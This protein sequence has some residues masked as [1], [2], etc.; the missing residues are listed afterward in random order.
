MTALCVALFNGVLTFIGCGPSDSQLSEPKECAEAAERLGYQVCVHTVTEEEIWQSVTAQTNQVTQPRTTKY[1]VPARK[2]ARLP[3]LF[4]DVGAFEMHLI[5]MV[6]AFPDIFP[7]LTA[8]EYERLILDPGERE[9][10]AGTIY[11]YNVDNNERIFGFVVWDE[12]KSVETTIECAEFKSV[13]AELSRV[14][15][16]GQLAV[17]PATGFQRDVLKDCDVPQYDPF[18]EIEYE[19]Y[20]VAMG[21]G[22]VRRYTLPE[23]SAATDAAEFGWQDI[24]ILDEAP[25]DIETVVSGAVTGTRQGALS[26]LNVRSA[27][28]NTPNCYLKNAYELFEEWEGELVRLQCGEKVLTVE[29]ATSEEA[30]EWW[31][32]LRPEPVAVLQPDLAARDF[33]GLLELPT[34]TAN[35]RATG[36]IRYGS[37]GLNLAALYQRIDPELQLVGFLIPF[38]YYDQFT[39]ANS[40]SVDMGSG[41]EQ[42]TF[43]ET[44]AKWLDNTSFY[45]DGALR[46][47]RLDA[48]RAA[49]RAAPCDEDLVAALESE[50][51]DRYGSNEV[52]VRF[53]SSSNAEDSLRFNGAGIYSSTSVCVAD[54]LDEDEVGPSRCD[55][56]QPNERGVCR[57]LTKV[58]SSLWRSVA[59]EERGWYGID[60]ND[61]AMGI[62]V[63]TRTKGELANIVAFSGNPTSPG[64]DRYLVNAQVGELDVVSAAPG[65]WPEKNLLTVEDGVVTEI[66][67]VSGSSELPD[68]AYAV[69]NEE[70][71][72]LGAVLWQ[73]ARDFPNDAETPAGSDLLFDTEWKIRGDGQLII[74]QVRPFLK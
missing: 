70:L 54:D 52:M 24:L 36:L 37:K 72:D 18:E 27:A 38:H 59:F 13:H 50:I 35:E 21:Y 23:L 64:D 65:V 8:E 39:S 49:M 2:G 6:N 48:V 14:F 74:K 5:F 42:L 44:I 31:N 51:V 57:G 7:G 45:T 11:E 26:H 58:W 61:V 40:W 19:P 28:R 9:F 20:T 53:R 46:R 69:S 22:T 67:R 25:L 3:T 66:D 60:H 43:A 33:V 68:G 62:L 71:G 32:E 56:D 15:T 29:A 16:I 30:E 4:M 34:D 63:N 1:I 12:Q 41:L 55:V 73:V 47:E 17:V 10:F